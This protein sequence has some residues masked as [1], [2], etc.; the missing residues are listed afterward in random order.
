MPQGIGLTL[1]NVLSEIAL[2]LW[3]GG[4]IPGNGRFY[5]PTRE[6]ER[7]MPEMGGISVG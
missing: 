5:S 4:Q 3:A 7:S 1:G 6:V 2:I